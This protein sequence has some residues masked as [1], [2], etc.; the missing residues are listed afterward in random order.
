M[1]KSIPVVLIEIAFVMIAAAGCSDEILATD[2]DQ[3]CAAD[4]DCATVFVGDICDCGCEVG[5]ISKQAVPEY[6]ERRADIRCST[7]CGECPDPKPAVCKSGV[8]AVE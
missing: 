6:S 4:A 2:F 8:C 7:S 3:T 5:A 1:G